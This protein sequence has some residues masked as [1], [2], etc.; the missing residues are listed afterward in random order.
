MVDDPFQL[1]L[2]GL[3]PGSRARIDGQFTDDAG[4][5][6]RSRG[7][8]QADADGQVDVC[9]DASIDGSYLGVEPRGLLWSA[10]PCAIEKRH[11]FFASRHSNPKAVGAS[12]WKDATSPV[13]LDFEAA[14]LEWH[15]QQPRTVAHANCTLLRQAPG[16][17]ATPVREGR[18]R[19]VLYEPAQ[20]LPST[21]LA[22]ALT[23]SN[24][25][26][27]SG[28]AAML[29][30]RGVAVFAQAFFAYED[31]SSE[32]VDVPLEMLDEGAQWLAQRFGRQRVGV[33]GGSRGGELSLLL[34][35]S[36]PDRFSAVVAVCA[37]H[38]V[39]GGLSASSASS[40]A[41]WTLGGQAVP[42]TDFGGTDPEASMVF[43]R[44]AWRSHRPMYLEGWTSAAETQS[45]IPVERGRAAVLLISGTNDE[46]WPASLGSER[47]IRRLHAHGYP[48]PCRHVAYQGAG[49]W[50]MRPAG[51]DS[52]L[53]D[54]M[55][56]PLIKVWCPLG[57]SAK[58]NADASLASFRE[59]CN[60]LHLY[61]TE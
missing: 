34:G 25:G 56:H 60:W 11:G 19:G 3:P 41:A 30:S 26:V 61:A 45:A 43:L 14:L 49:H 38:L 22:I 1:V 44:E 36:F 55:V 47:V 40:V 20:V 8:F 4:G 37:A 7:V 29:A 5:V 2:T 13:R 35:A 10:A 12:T 24:G 54:G 52:S 16:V 27:S 48:Y 32:L 31:L 23:G 6:W 39:H 42:Y 18:L 15:T 59:A 9:T 33:V 21:P 57:G 50:V 53:S 51:I 28:L 17:R 46:L 58:A